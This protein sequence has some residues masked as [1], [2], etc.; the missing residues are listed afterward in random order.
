ANTVAVPRFNFCATVRIFD[1]DRGKCLRKRLLV[2]GIADHP[3]LRR[4][5]WVEINT[6]L[7]SDQKHRQGIDSLGFHKVSLFWELKKR[8]VLFGQDYP[9]TA[10][11]IIGLQWD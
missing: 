4:N 7:R 3:G 2:N 1:F 10:A 9:R 8:D 5:G 6:K 11:Q